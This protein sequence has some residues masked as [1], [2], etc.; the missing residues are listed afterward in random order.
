MTLAEARALGRRWDLA[1][2]AVTPVPAGSVNSS[3]ALDTDEGARWFLRV[4]EE[5]G[6]DGARAEARM[7]LALAAEGVPTPP[8][9]A[10]A[11]EPGAFV[12]EHRGRPA[13]VFA[14]VPGAMV[15]QRGVTPRHARSVGLAL[16][17][18][19]RAGE[20]VE[21]LRPS[22]FGSAALRAR[23]D[24][25]RARALPKELQRAVA[26]LSAT[27]DGLDA[28]GPARE[29][30]LIH[31]DLF[32]D[33][34]LWEGEAL[35]ALL[36]FESASLGCAAF[37]LAVTLLAWCFGDSLD[38]GLARALV[39]GYRGARELRPEERQGLHREARRAA[40]RF[41]VTRITDFELR[42]GEVAV[43]K[44]WR[45]FEARLRAVEAIAPDQLQQALGLRG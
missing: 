28:E 16:A 9:R 42:R 8:P 26:S 23:L 39:E 15:C 13:A 14:W 19:H 34:V 37:D 45:R 31:G 38:L 2:R 44:D 25:L 43:Y 1:V 7:L 5:Q 27:L 21:G 10:L 24:A 36:D 41:T 18:V 4:Y 20:A 40:L 29:T 6:P 32:R 11:G 12:S 3:Y 33:N 22:R 30:T 17:K 35:R